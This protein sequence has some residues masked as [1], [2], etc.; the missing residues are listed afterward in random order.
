M[1][2]QATGQIVAE[3]AFVQIDAAGGVRAVAGRG[4]E[5]G[6]GLF[7]D[8]GVAAIIRPGGVGPGDVRH[9][10]EF[11]EE[12]LIVGPLGRAGGGPAMDEYVGSMVRR[13][14]VGSRHAIGP[15]G[16]M[17]LRGS[18]GHPPAAAKRKFAINR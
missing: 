18:A 16:L 8:I 17:P 14:W 7:E 13:G 9:V 3:A 11:G 5:K 10:A 4:G 6:D 15:L 12:P 1:R 2:Q